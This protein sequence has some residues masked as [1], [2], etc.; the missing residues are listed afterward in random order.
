MGY[1]LPLRSRDQRC[2]RL[3]TIYVV[4]DN[5]NHGLVFS[6]LNWPPISPDLNKVKQ[7][8]DPMKDE[9]CKYSRLFL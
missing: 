1:P 4:E 5:A 8:W 6:P 9:I 2:Y 3:E 7:C